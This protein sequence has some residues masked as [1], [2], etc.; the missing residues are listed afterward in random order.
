MI[1]RNS[2]FHFSY[3][4]IEV[5]HEPQDFIYLDD[6]SVS[7]QYRGNGIGT[8]LIETAQKFA[9]EMAMPAIVL[10]AEKTN[11]GAVRLY[12]RLGY[13]MMEEENTRLRMV[14]K[15]R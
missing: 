13:R 5:H 10:H 6:L 3:L 15:L 4:S 9:E 1:P 8:E 2:F 14:K 11:T 7:K 12:E